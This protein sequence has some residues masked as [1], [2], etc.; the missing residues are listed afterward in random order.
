MGSYRPL[1]EQT[2]AVTGPYEFDVSL[3]LQKGGK[4]VFLAAGRALNCAA[5]NVRVSHLREHANTTEKIWAAKIF[6]GRTGE[7]SPS[8]VT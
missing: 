5:K 6:P 2:D 1:S 7:C 3:Q 4:I 8:C